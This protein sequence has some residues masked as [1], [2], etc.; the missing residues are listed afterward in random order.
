MK[1]KDFDNWTLNKWEDIIR[2]YND[3]L[4]AISLKRYRDSLREFNKVSKTGI[5]FAN[6]SRI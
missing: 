1:D 3:L 5:F 6:S 4:P 2:A